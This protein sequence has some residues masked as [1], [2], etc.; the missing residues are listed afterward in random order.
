MDMSA[1]VGALM[2]SFLKLAEGLRAGQPAQEQDS[3]EINAL[4]ATVPHDPDESL[5]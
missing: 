4:L 3:D 5:R 1:I 2:P